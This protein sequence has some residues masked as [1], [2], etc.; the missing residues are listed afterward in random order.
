MNQIKRYWKENRYEL[1]TTFFIFTNLFP[2]WFPQWVYYISFVLILYKMMKHKPLGN[3]PKTILF[4]GFIAF[5]WVTTIVGNA[6]DLRLVIFSAILFIG[7]PRRSIQWHNYKIKLLFNIFIGFGIATLVNFYAK[8]I[9]VN[10]IR[11]DEYMIAMGRVAEFSGYAS[12]AMWTSC[13]AALSAVFFTSIAFQR[14]I[15]NDFLRIGCYSMILI[16][17]YIAMIAASRSAFFLSLACSALIIKMQSMK[18]SILFRNALIVGVTAFAFTPFL[19]DNSQAMMNKR[20]GLQ[21]T[22]KNTSRDALWAERMEEFRSSPII[23]IGFAAH[24]VGA[25]KQVGRN[26][27]GGSF[28]SVLAQAGI[29]GIFFI[30]MI[31]KAAIM[32]PS[33]IGKDPHLILIYA[34]FV[35]FSI[36]CIIE[37]YMFQAGWYL[38]LIIWLIIGV[39]I[40]HKLYKDRIAQTI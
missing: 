25:N 22:T 34:G 12:F 33:R 7:M 17:L 1:I 27:S 21:I 31:W 3:T 26:E 5:L 9:G 37:G 38:C 13:A 16:S 40:E 20:N 35:F 6:L 36:H 24:G 15:K 18:M 14:K 32:K 2:Q 29:V 4:T 11:Q 8:L 10:L 30:V 19:M 39:M 23:G 28:I